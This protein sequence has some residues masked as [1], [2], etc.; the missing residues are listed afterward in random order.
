MNTA[1]QHKHFPT[2]TEAM[3]WLKQQGYTYDFNLDKDCLTYDS[4]EKRL[5]P[6]EFNIDEVFRFEGMTDPGDE[7]IV[8]A[9]SSPSREV[10]GV[11]VNAYG[12]YADAV[13]AKMIR[14]LA[15]HPS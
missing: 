14:K 9:I 12:P 3:A 1:D 13:S 5:D 8:Y 11:L 4:G 15:T 2:V 7:N 6:E 10:K